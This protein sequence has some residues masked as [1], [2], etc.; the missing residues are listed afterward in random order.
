MLGEIVFYELAGGMGET[1]LL[2][3]GW[4][5]KTIQTG[6]DRGGVEGP[7]VE[8]SG[9]GLQPLDLEVRRAAGSGNCHKF[10]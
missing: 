4:D 9:P 6:W 10:H 3:Y 7:A 1:G 8:G 2:M 5:G